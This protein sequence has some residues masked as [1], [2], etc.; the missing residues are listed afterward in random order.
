MQNKTHSFLISLYNFLTDNRASEKLKAYEEFFG[1]KGDFSRKKEY[2][3][4]YNKTMHM[5][6]Q[7]YNLVGDEEMTLDDFYGILDA[8]FDEIEIG[9]I[10]QSVDRVIVGDMERTRLNSVKYLF[11]L[12]LNDGWVPKPGGKGGI[13]SDADREFLADSGQEMAPSPRKQMYIGRF[14][15][16]SNITKPSD[17][18]Y[19]SYTAMDGEASAMRPS[20]VVDMLKKIFQQVTVEDYR[21]QVALPETMKEARELYAVL[22]R[23]Y[24]ES[25]MDDNGKQLLFALTDI[26]KGRPDFLEAM[27]NNA[28]F[29][30]ND[31][32]L[33]SVISA[34]LY[35]TRLSESISKFEKFA[36]C[37]YSY[38]LKYGMEL[39]DSEEYG[40][41]AA[42]MGN[43]YHGVLSIF[44][45]LMTERGTDWF[46]ITEE[47]IDELVKEAVNREAVEYTDSILFDS[48]KNRY[49]ILIFLRTF[50]VRFFS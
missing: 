26:L 28:F 2:S 6:E 4:V 3:Q 48:S 1:E 7:V 20:Y 9:M 44:N 12:G 24:A 21:S 27:I 13:I 50:S 38:F 43:I 29:R 39:E 32:S 18:L 11:F 37:A 17:G 47:E 49:I 41:D 31:S 10:P 35:G 16:Y 22:I 45:S 42:D 14:Y 15:L 33:D 36:Q 40:V 30:Y 5:L 19:L 34:I 8:G 46:N 25:G 23:K